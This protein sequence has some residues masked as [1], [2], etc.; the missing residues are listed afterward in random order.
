M[1]GRRGAGPAAVSGGWG[2]LGVQGLGG[3]RAGVGGA[4]G[5]REGFGGHFG[6]P[7]TF[8]GGSQRPRP[9]RPRSGG[10]GGVPVPRRF[11]EAAESSFPSPPPTPLLP[12]F[13]RNGPN[14]VTFPAPGG[15]PGDAPRIPGARGA[16]AAPTPLCLRAGFRLF[17]CFGAF[18][19]LSPNPAPPALCAR[20]PPRRAG[21]PAARGALSALGGEPPAPSALTGRSLTL[22][23]QRE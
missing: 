5:S 4:G 8:G 23:N 15:A 3:G 17:P 21:I 1:P 2:G 16:A 12:A 9:A 14:S 6:V 20:D 10:S 22:I 11:P 18:F 7:V 19:P 13:A